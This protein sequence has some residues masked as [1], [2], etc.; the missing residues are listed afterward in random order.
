MPKPN[1]AKTHNDPFIES[2]PDSREFSPDVEET[3][4]RFR[5]RLFKY[6]LEDI[7]IDVLT[8]RMVYEMSFSDIADILGIP[9]RQIAYNIYNTA[10]EQLRE[11]GFC[12]H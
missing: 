9:S 10:I 1:S 3:E 8:Y 4:L 7:R 6:G 12:E 11:R 2:K 5:M